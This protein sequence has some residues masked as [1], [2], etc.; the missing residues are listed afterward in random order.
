MQAT[1]WVSYSWI[2]V[3]PTGLLQSVL[4]VVHHACLLDIDFQDSFSDCP[5]FGLLEKVREIFCLN[6]GIP[7]PRTFRQWLIGAETYRQV[8]FRV[9]SCAVFMFSSFFP[10]R[11]MCF[12]I[13]SDTLL[14]LPNAWTTQQ[15]SLKICDGFFMDDFSKTLQKQQFS[16]DHFDLLFVS[17]HS[18][19]CPVCPGID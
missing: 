9:C 17:V 6:F 10:S 19:L 18:E 1:S 2:F 4:L 14:P 16:W 5:A 13:Q 15:K 11:K 3:I 7:A 8:V 12:L